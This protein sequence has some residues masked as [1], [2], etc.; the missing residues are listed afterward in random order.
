MIALVLTAHLQL[1]VYTFLDTLHFLL[2]NQ[3][4]S[5]LVAYVSSQVKRQGF[6]NTYEDTQTTP[7]TMLRYSAS[8]R[9]ISSQS[10][11]PVEGKNAS[12]KENEFFV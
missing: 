11:V 10:V 12:Q 1:H 5:I 9:S 4:A 2:V 8:L 3:H 6:Y 7:P